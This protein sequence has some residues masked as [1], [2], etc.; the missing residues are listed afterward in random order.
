M[1]YD[2]PELYDPLTARILDHLAGFEDVRLTGFFVQRSKDREDPANPRNYKRMVPIQYQESVHCLA[3][4]LHVLAAVRGGVAA[5][6]ADGVRLEAAPTP[7]SRRTRRRTRTSSTAGAGSGR[8]SAT[9][10]SKG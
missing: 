3:F 10:G 2:F 4:V 9:C 5:A 7:T 1:L 6:L 8:R